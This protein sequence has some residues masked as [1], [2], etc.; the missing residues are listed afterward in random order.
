[1]LHCLLLEKNGPVKFLSIIHKT[2]RCPLIVCNFVR[3]NLISCAI[4]RAVELESES[5]GI[6][7]GVGVGKNIPTSTSI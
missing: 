4:A 3:Y 6:L 1:V 7:G 5:E 2:K